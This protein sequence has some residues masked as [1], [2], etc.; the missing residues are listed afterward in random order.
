MSGEQ[1]MNLYNMRNILQYEGLGNKQLFPIQKK[2]IVHT[3]LSD[4][5]TFTN[6]QQ[7]IIW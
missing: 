6:P 2:K 1:F 3:T 5:T 7:T 4:V